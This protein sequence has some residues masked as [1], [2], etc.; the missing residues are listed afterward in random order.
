MRG[1]FAVVDGFDVVAIRVEDVRGVVRVA[2]LR[3]HAGRAVVLRARLERGGMKRV[4]RLPAGSVERDVHAPSRTSLVDPE[5][6]APE[7]PER[8]RT[9]VAVDER[10]TLET[11]R[12]QR[13]RIEVE[14][15]VEVAHADSDVV[16]D[17]VP[18]LHGRG[19]YATQVE[20]RRVP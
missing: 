6:V 4:D 3:A 17:A 5:L 20:G 19:G 12:R 18:D 10:D 11:Q 1:A 16:D 15:R 9:V 13:A 14:T 2:V 8:R 7:R